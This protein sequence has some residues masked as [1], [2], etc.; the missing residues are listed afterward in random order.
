MKTN[1]WCVIATHWDSEYFDEQSIGSTRVLSIRKFMGDIDY[2]TWRQ[3]KREGW[4]CVKVSMTL[5][6]I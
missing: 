1:K 3:F 6:V 5:E 2:K 4:K